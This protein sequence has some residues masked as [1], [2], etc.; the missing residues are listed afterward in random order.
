MKRVREKLPRYFN[1]IDFPFYD[2]STIASEANKNKTLYIDY[3]HLTPEGSEAIA[4]NMLEP[5]KQSV[6]ESIQESIN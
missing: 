4:S 3:C 6:M 1:S 5:L 2:V